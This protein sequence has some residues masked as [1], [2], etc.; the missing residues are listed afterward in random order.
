MLAIT[1][2]GFDGR[3]PLILNEFRGYAPANESGDRCFA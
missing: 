3:G 2:E 1:P